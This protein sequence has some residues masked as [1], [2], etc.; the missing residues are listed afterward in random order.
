MSGYVFAY[1][2]IGLQSIGDPHF[3]QGEMVPWLYVRIRRPKAG[4]MQLINCEDSR[5][6]KT[7]NARRPLNRPG[8]P[9]SQPAIY[10]T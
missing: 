7:S 2:N 4:G 8:A 6:A 9:G 10:F 1:K 3:F 5:Q